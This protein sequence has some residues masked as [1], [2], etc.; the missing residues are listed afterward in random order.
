MSVGWNPWHGCHRV[1]PG[2]AHCYVYRIDHA[3]GKDSS[4]VENNREFDL[5]VRHKRDGSFSIPFGQR[6][7]TCFSSDFLLEEADH[8]RPEAWSMMRARPDLEF[9]FA[10][11]RIARLTQCLPEDWGD[12]YPNLH[13]C[14]TVEDQLRAQERLPVFLAAPVRKKSILCEPLLEQVELSPYLCPEIRE[15]V[16]GGESG[17]QARLCRY[18]WVL[19]IRE[20]CRRAGVAFTFKQTGAR[21][22]KDGRIYHVPRSQQHVQAKKAGIDLFSV[23]SESAEKDVK[24]AF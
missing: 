10:T 15:V 23:L 5:P 11:K 14:C 24:G 18:G 7:Y 22:E 12:G 13:I 9:F 6:V 21:F 4:R 17:P 19:N 1:S 3:H 20:Q 2:C 8:W 16:V